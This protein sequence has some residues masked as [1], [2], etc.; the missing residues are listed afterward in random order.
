MSCNEYYDQEAT[1]N[2]SPLE[3][4]LNVSAPSGIK[5][6]ND[7]FQLKEKLTASIGMA[8]SEFEITEIKY[9]PLKEGYAALITYLTQDGSVGNIGL[10]NRRIAIDK[11]LDVKINSSSRRL[12]TRSEHTDILDLGAFTIVCKPDGSGCPSCVVGFSIGANDE[13]NYW[14]ECRTSGVNEGCE[15]HQHFNS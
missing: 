9:L 8:I 13:V 5:I 2:L 7:V 6:V 15:M 10:T 11:N 14:C 4:S 3:T 1:G 12:L